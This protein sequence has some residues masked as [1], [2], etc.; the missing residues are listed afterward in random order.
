MEVNEVR[1]SLGG[2]ILFEETLLKHKS[3]LDTKYKGQPL[4]E[5]LQARGIIPG[6]KT[7]KGTVTLEGT[8]P[9]ETTTSG[10]DGLSERSEKYYEAGAR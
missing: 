7:D 10:L 9:E 1:N 4:V 8:N 6:I 3:N 2:V 5:V